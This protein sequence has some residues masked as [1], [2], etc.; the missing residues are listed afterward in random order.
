MLP[1]FRSAA[2]GLLALTSAVYALPQSQTDSTSDDSSSSSSSNSSTA[3]NN[4]PELCSRTYNNVTHM[5]AH[6]SSFLRDAGTFASAGNQNLNATEALDAGIRLLQAQVHDQNDT[7]RLCHTSCDILDAGPLEDWLSKI[8]SWMDNNPDDVVTLLLVNSDKASADSFGQLFNNSGL[9]DS[10][11]TPTGEAPLAEWPTL[12]TMIDN[13]QRLVSF[14]T[15][16]N[17][18]TNYPYLMSEFKYVFETSFEV[19]NLADFN[20]SIDRPS[21]LEDQDGASAI[22]S[23]YLSLVNHFKYQSLGS[24]L[25]IPDV[26]NIE[27]V[28]S[29]NTTEDGELGL[30]LQECQ[31]QWGSAP[32]FVLVDLIEKGDVLKAADRMNGISDATGREAMTDDGDEDSAGAL[33][34]RRMGMVALVS[35]VAAS[36][37]LV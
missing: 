32:N 2:V 18:T 11:F 7:L 16:I 19:S 5:G 37:I 1:S 29:A 27:T 15:N 35:F 13:N 36:M 10:A 30:H 17:A 4:S 20:C 33:P 3:C 22:A 14:I 8:N 28:N 6:G 34:D 24:D 9:A 21:K 26:S 23:N 12:Q 25:F 31:K